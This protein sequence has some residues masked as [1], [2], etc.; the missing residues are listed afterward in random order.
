MT[1]V[2]TLFGSPFVIYVS[3]FVSA[4]YIAASAFCANG[5]ANAAAAS[6]RVARLLRDM[7]GH[8][9]DVPRREK[10]RGRTGCEMKAMSWLKDALWLFAQ[11]H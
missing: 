6:R 7:A 8:V 5:V 9:R 11:K 1:Y 2:S 10:A 4:E 3:G